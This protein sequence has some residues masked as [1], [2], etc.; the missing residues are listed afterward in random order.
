MLSIVKISCYGTHQSGTTSY[1][2]TYGTV[3]DL[4]NSM[5]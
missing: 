1:G 3:F 4:R 2:F 5:I